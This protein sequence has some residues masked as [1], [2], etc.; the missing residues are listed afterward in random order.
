MTER[1]DGILSINYFILFYQVRKAL[2]DK[3]SLDNKEWAGILDTAADNGFPRY[4]LF[5][6]F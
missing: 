1:T 4:S 5:F 3:T 6:V 2:K